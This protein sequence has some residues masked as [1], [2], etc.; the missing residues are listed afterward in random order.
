MRLSADI[1]KPAEVL[2][3]LIQFIPSSGAHSGENL[4]VRRLLCRFLIVPS[5][6][7]IFKPGKS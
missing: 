6:I 2:S 5:V 3:S 7:S 4:F 1:L